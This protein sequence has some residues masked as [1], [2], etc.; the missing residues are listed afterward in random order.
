MCL[1]F[2]YLTANPAESGYRLIVASNRDEFW[3]RPTDT[4]AF[5]DEAKWIGG[6]DLEPGKEGG[7]WLGISRTGRMAVLLN[8]LAKQNP[9]AKGRG[10]L[11]WDFLTSDVS[12][13]EYISHVASQSSQYNP[14]HLLLLDLRKS[15]DLHIVSSCHQSKTKV[16]SQGIH[17]ADNSNDLDQPWRKRE[18]GKK[19][20]SH[21]ITEHGNTSESEQLTKK[22]FELLNDKTSYFPDECLARAF[23]DVGR[24]TTGDLITQRSA[25]FVHSPQYQYGTRT[26]TVIL[27]DRQGNCDYIE[28]THSTPIDIQNPTWTTVHKQFK[29][30]CDF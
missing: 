17:A 19:I 10:Q 5:R 12:C 20:F 14:F 13:Q 1:L 23:A 29:L 9:Q 6:I 4:A 28:R 24:P 8:I 18:E 21:I 16:L 25:V 3:N 2:V 30:E 15:C 22:L 7:T 11:V 26:N 27:L